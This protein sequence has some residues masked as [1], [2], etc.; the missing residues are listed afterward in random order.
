MDQPD[1]QANGGPEITGL[2]C[3]S[4]KVEPGYLFA[5]LPGAKADGAAFIRDALSK[6][7][8]AVLSSPDVQYDG[9]DPNIPVITDVEPRRRYAKL[10][11]KFFSIQPQ[12]I[13]LV[14]GTNGKTSVAEFTRQLW[15]SVGR[16]AGS[17][18][19]IGLNAPGFA[20][21][22][23][24][25]TPDAADLHRMLFDLSHAG[26]EHL[27][28][29]ASSHGLSQYRLDG[30]RAGAAAFTNLSRDHLDYHATMEDYFQ[31]KARLFSEV[32][33]PGG[34]AVLN[35]DSDRF[36]ALK[37][38]C[39]EVGHPV[40][41]Y[42][43]KAN[44]IRLVD[45]TPL[46]TGQLVRLSF[47]GSDVEMTLPLVGDFQVY[48]ALAAFGL[49]VSTGG[50]MDAGLHG[51]EALKGAAGR[52]EFIGMTDNKA[53]VFVDYAHTPD[54]LETALKAL[55]PH[56]TASL[57]VVFGCGGDRDKGKRPE[58]GAAANQYADRIY[59][60]DD[61]PRSEQADDIRA[62]IMAATPKGID[63]PGRGP[64]IERAIAELQTGDCL[65]IAGKGHETGQI[66]GDQVLPFDDRKLA[67]A[68]IGGDQ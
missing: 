15:A 42:G 53:S 29:E 12:T 58:M 50:T 3:D 33:T 30:L 62:A 19:T 20:G 35:A 13:A 54:A 57:A 47:D 44:A 65:I 4:R 34:T 56:T 37:A 8:A 48:N 5:A 60:T 68:L 2:T 25:T 27:C 9:L 14:T 45:I 43:R 55:R 31:A 40:L 52:M 26:V 67:S 41:D 66:V 38:I 7:A 46:P 36:D 1:T 18:G 6:G 24:L 10:A 21:G 23:G 51:L 28:I 59:V 11:A 63:C 22:P 39:D 64:A 17:L 49:F 61:N 32:L 16:K